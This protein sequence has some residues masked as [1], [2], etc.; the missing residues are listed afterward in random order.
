MLEGEAFRLSRMAAE[1][2]FAEARALDS[3]STVD[4]WH[5]ALTKNAEALSHW[6]AA[7]NCEVL[8]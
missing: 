4:S 3:R 5:L 1:I 7:G 2:A 8:L 6:R